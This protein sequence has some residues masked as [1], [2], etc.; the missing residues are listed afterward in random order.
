M[1]E[2]KPVWGHLDDL[3]KVLVR[4]VIALFVT[5]SLSFL[6]A[7]FLLG[8]L[9]KPYHTLLTSH[10]N[11]SGGLM[12]LHPTES[13]MM[14]MHL[15]LTSGVVL[16]FPLLVRFVWQF[17]GTGLYPKE[18]KIVLPI[19]YVG[20][21]LFILGSLFAF[22]F[23][24]PKVLDFFWSYNLHLG[25]VPAWTVSHYLSFVLLFLLAFGLA[26]ELPLLVVG[27][28]RLGFIS[29]ANL[30]VGRPYVIVG[31]FIVGAILTPPDVV[32]QLALSLPMWGLFELSLLI[33]RWGEKKK[34][35]EGL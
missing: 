32:S 35:K 29:T 33:A 22:Y 23:V 7:D 10:H 5:S 6:F 17:V 2:R 26:F 34:T 21:A 27:A 14:S 1:E 9:L 30:A 31:I 13:F 16:A 4:S 18:R 25:I 20:T 11:T 8:F 3:R 19:L 28:T 15:A 12:S 24:V